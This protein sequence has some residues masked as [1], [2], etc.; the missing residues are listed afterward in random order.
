MKL[1]NIILKN[2]RQFYGEQKLTFSIDDEKNTTLIHAENGTGKTAF[3]N[4]ILWCFFEMNTSNFKEPTVLLNKV[5]KKNGERNYSV[6][7]EFVDEDGKEYQVNRGYDHT[8]AGKFF[9]VFEIKG[10]YVTPDKIRN[11]QSFIN[12]V[13]PK[14]M[15]K[16][17]F[18]QGE[19]I[20]KISSSSKSNSVVK[21]AVR[22]I[23][24]FTIAEKALADTVAIRKE[25]QK[26]LSNADKTG[27][28]AK[29]EGEIL[30]REESL[31]KAQKKLTDYVDS[32]SY[33]DSALQDADEK[34]IN[35]DS[36]VIKE[37]HK[38][39]LNTENQI[40]REKQLIDN[41]NIEK[42]H[43]I[44]EF[45]TTVFG[46]QLSNEVIDFI[47][48]SEYQGKVPAPYNEQL[49]KSILEESTCVCGADIHPGS[50]AFNR[51]QQMLEKASD[52][53]LEDRIIK[54]RSQ[55][56][57]IKNS[58]Q[59]AKTRFVTNM[60]AL[61]DAETNLAKNK[62]ELDELS[63]KIKGAESLD[64]IEALESERQRVK[65]NLEEDKKAHTRT[66]VQIEQEHSALEK[67]KAQRDRLDT[68]SGEMAKY[69]KLSEVAEKVSQILQKTIQ[70]AEKDVE[71]R[72]IDKVNKY[73]ELFVRQDYRA[74]FQN[75]TFD[76]RLTDR[77]GHLVPESDGQSLLLSLTFISSLIELS[78]E[79][80]NAKG[81]ILTPGAIAPFVIDAPFG[82]LDNKYKGDI[83]KAIPQSVE[84][85]IVMLSSSHW[86][87]TVEESIRSKVG[88]E[89]NM[90]LEVT[91]NGEGKSANNINVLDGVYETVRYEMPVER[92]VIEEIGNYVR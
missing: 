35:S 67:A 73:L 61:A 87:G 70:S 46:Y 31:R 16:Y 82:D 14:D 32:I 40:K 63:I 77:D 57:S 3:L 4:S 53:N 26:S 92:T 81:Q 41:A 84:Q 11:P 68:Y 19:G 54:A 86:E 38:Q 28:V 24:G 18:F 37:L 42:R 75:N 23:L 27:E 72:I 66:Q 52:P 62:A 78:R 17:F 47:D 80:K 34:L 44:A 76:I 58:F 83:A 13:I 79:R 49:V 15:A 89:Y 51:I 85:V 56:T 1:K 91:S 2:F 64:K 36:L 55:L 20:G 88:S 33:F 65:R 43:L 8:G 7:I 60:N 69:K 30:N 5:A 21:T 39:R 71:R 48:D 9:Y 74:I 22:E 10:G 6:S 45:A 12:S 50:E 29:L 59:R 90:V 25:Y